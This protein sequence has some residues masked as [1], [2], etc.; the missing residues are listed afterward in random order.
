[1]AETLET[2]TCQACGEGIRPKALF[3]FNCGSQVGSDEEVEI[4]NQNQL[5][6]SNAWFKEE[7]TEAK[8]AETIPFAAKTKKTEPRI[9]RPLE[10]RPKLSDNTIAE[11]KEPVFELKTAASLR[12]KSKLATKKTV[13][14]VWEEPKSAP[15]IWFLIVSLILVGFSVAILYAMLYLR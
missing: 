8:A 15:N 5:K 2:Q 12:N 10:V 9:E 7:I 11:K 13:E 6:I 3:C 14:V 1:M 4:E